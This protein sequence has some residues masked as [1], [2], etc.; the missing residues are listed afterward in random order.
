MIE[1]FCNIIQLITTGICTAVC[2]RHALLSGKRSSYMLSLASF[3]Y[4][5]G[6]IY[7][8]LYMVFYDSTPDISYISDCSWYS[9]YLFLFL[10][11]IDMRDKEQKKYKSRLLWIIPVFTVGMCFFYMQWGQY[12]EN[13]ICAVLMGLLIWQAS[14]GV[15]YI[16]RC[17]EADK[18]KKWMYMSVLFF[19][20]AEYGAW[21]TSTFWLGDTWINPY[22]WFDLLLSISF[23][24][25]PLAYRKVV[26]D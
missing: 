4:F 16:H 21:T 7:W 11:L 6:D 2:F 12:L 9:T 24:L 10:L 14:D 23:I 22:F 17:K 19:C 26:K 15:I 8:E 20:F 3:V 18:R 25:F 5:L 1:S 13:V